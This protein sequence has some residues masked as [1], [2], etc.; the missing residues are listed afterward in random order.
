M[1]YVSITFDDGREDNYSVAFPVLKNKKLTATIYCTTGFIDKSWEKKSD[2]YSAEKAINIEQLHELKKNG[3]EIALHGDKHVTE[4]DDSEI[5]LNKFQSWGF[6]SGPIGMSL[7]DSQ[8]NSSLYDFINHF[9]PN[10]ISYI[11]IGR[12]RDTKKLSSRILF[13]LYTFLKVQ[14]AYDA[15]NKPSVL[16]T[17]DLKLPLIP[18]VVVRLSD[19]PSMILSFIESLADNTWVS[20]M[21]HSIHK[22]IDIYQNDPWNWPESKLI[23]FCDGLSKMRDQGFI[24]VIPMIDVIKKLNLGDGRGD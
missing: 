12:A 11:R 2:W 1:K 24:D 8:K 10:V 3:W 15:F 22:D 19:N 5:A 17:T 7:P 4:I 13:G 18:S 20:I 16:Q 21:L 6:L 23:K 14:K 9:Y